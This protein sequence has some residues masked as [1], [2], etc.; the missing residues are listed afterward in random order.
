MYIGLAL[1]TLV[2]VTPIMYDEIPVGVQ[3]CKLVQS[4]R[5]R[6]SLR[7]VIGLASPRRK[8]LDADALANRRA[9][10]RQVPSRVL[11]GR[12]PI[13][14]ECAL[15]IDLWLGDDR[16]VGPSANA[17]R[18]ASTRRR[19]GTREKISAALGDRGVITGLLRNHGF[20]RRK[21]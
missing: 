10:T 3:S 6:R 20:P 4:P 12:M 14:V 16:C 18:D 11:N 5:P 21:S 1:L 7:Q 19:E 13:K 9:V 15:R 8:W 17:Q 2:V